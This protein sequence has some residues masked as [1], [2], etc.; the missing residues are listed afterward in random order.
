MSRDFRARLD[1]ILRACDR[2][3]AY[4]AGFD[5]PAFDAVIRNLEVVGEA[6]IR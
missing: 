4:L 6:V 5:R 2:I 1:D 3:A